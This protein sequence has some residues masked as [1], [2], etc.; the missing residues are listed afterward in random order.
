MYKNELKTSKT[1]LQELVI[2]NSSTRP[3]Y[4]R[5]KSSKYTIDNKKIAIII[6]RPQIHDLPIFKDL[7]KSKTSITLNKLPHIINAI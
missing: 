5:L 3:A 1:R 7:Y 6:T 4:R 2:P